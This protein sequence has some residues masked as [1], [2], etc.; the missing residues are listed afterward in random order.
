MKAGLS[1]QIAQA[2]ADGRRPDAMADDEAAAYDL[3]VEIQRGKHVSDETYKKAVG[4]FGE[5]GVID[6]L[7]ISGYYTLLAMTMNATR[8]SMPDGIAEPLK[9]F[10]E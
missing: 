2:I 3:A 10:P 1:P 8:T 5:Q 9:R 4:K 6:I 7:G